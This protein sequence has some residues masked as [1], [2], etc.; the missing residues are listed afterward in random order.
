M[1]LHHVG[2]GVSA[3]G[4]LGWG[5]QAHESGP[6]WWPEG[7]PI[8]RW[9]VERRTAVLDSAAVLQ[10]RPEGPTKCRAFPLCAPA[11]PCRETLIQVLAFL[12]KRSG[13]Q[14]APREE[15]GGR[16]GVWNLPSRRPADE[17]EAARFRCGSE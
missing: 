1:P 10:W 4:S 5:V 3:G 16:R 6:K 12:S 2:G 17:R 8:W 9:H 15:G 11:S 13:R 7:P 14:A